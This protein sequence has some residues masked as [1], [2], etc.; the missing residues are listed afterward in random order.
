M[1][2]AKIKTAQELL[3]EF[4]KSGFQAKF[5]KDR[6][7]R[8]GKGWPLSTCASDCAISKGCHNCPVFKLEQERRAQGTCKRQKAVFLEENLGMPESLTTPRALFAFPQGDMFHSDITDWNIA[9]VMA[10]VDN[11]PGH[12]FTLLTKRSE[13]MGELFGS[14]EF[15]SL[16]EKAGKA[17][18]GPDFRLRKTFGDNVFAGVSVEEQAYVLRTEVYR[19]LPAT[20]SWVLFVSPMLGS[21]V[22]PAWVLRSLAWAV[23]NKEIGGTYSKPRPCRNEWVVSLTAQCDEYGVPFHT[24]DRF[25]PEMLGRLGVDCREF[26]N[27]KFF[28]AA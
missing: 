19:H 3:E 25:T 7:G 14:N 11:N 17:R 20:M 26:P 4:L 13:R 21:V 22:L 6:W 5:L 24:Q 10:V 1:S 9:T 18:Y 16:V 28:Q 15:W 23:Q 12:L 8:Q 27:H 2:C